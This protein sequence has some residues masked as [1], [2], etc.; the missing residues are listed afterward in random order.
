M[1]TFQKTIIF[2]FI[3]LLTLNS[4]VSADEAVNIEK[5]ET[6]IEAFQGELDEYSIPV[7]LYP[8]DDKLFFHKKHFEDSRD[9][10]ML[11]GITGAVLL[12]VGGVLAVVVPDLVWAPY[13]MSTGISY[14]ITLSVVGAGAGLFSLIG[15]L[16]ETN[17][18][19]TEFDLYYEETY[20][21]YK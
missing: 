18:Y 19:K 9:N 20:R 21:H 8:I 14:G 10:G 15:I 11:V 5:N 7:N 13:G 4:V 12:G 6:I 16:P 2:V 1:S 3:V 17:K